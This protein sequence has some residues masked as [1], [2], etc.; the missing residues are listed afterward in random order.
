MAP[1]PRGS[2][3]SFPGALPDVHRHHGHGSRLR[4]DRTRRCAGG[5]QRS[6]SRQARSSPPRSRLVLGRPVPT[7]PRTSNRLTGSSISTLDLS[8]SSE[9]VICPS[10]P[11]SEHQRSCPIPKGGAGTPLTLL[12]PFTARDCQVKIS[13][14]VRLLRLGMVA[15]ALTTRGTCV[16]D[17]CE[18][19]A[20]GRRSGSARDPSRKVCRSGYGAHQTAISASWDSIPHS[21][22][23]S[24]KAPP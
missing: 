8:V 21:G 24:P 6:P 12:S 9:I 1:W 15:A 17:R 13:G 5:R 10:P 4:C 18:L 23:S 20:R 11:G 16:K 2:A 14:S 22:D 3:C 19:E 7:A